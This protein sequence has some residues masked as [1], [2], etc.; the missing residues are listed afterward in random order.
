MEGFESE[1]ERDSSGL[2]K[3]N[4]MTGFGC[5]LRGFTIQKE[6]KKTR[7]ETR[8]GITRGIPELRK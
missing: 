2:I 5:L 6:K 4:H 8:R 1:R 7:E 3:A